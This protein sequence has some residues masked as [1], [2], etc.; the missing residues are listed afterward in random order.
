[1]R[2]RRR[3]R[4]P[5]VLVP[6]LVYVGV[7]VVAPAVNGAATGEAYAEHAV[8]TLGVSGAVLM[9][10]L[11]AGRIRPGRRS[12]QQHHARLDGPLGVLEAHEVDARGDVLSGARA[13]V[14]DE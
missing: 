14:P 8:I 10:W 6:W 7:T 4:L 13:A 12:P 3:P 2:P 5:L 11:T 1:M 9:L